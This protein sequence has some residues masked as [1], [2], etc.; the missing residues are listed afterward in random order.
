MNETQSDRLTETA[1]TVDLFESP[2][3][4][5]F[6]YAD[7]DPAVAA[8]ARATIARIK[9]R[10]HS[11]VCETGRDLIRI[12]RQMS[13]GQFGRWVACELGI[14]LRAAQNYMNVARFVVG[15]SE[16][17]SLLPPSALYA[18]AAPSASPAIVDEVLTA[19]NTGTPISA[20]EIRQKLN[21]PAA[22]RRTR[23]AVKSDEQLTRAIDNEKRRWSADLAR[24][25]KAEEEHE[26]AEAR[27]N[28]KALGV[29]QFLVTRLSA[30]DITELLSLLDDETDWNL[31]ET[32]FHC[33]DEQQ[34]STDET[35][36][37]CVP[38]T[39]S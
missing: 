13:H 28:T 21:A 30:R 25:K 39:Q 1:T 10:L 8:D 32:Y 36:T 14:S 7:I 33:L 31:V 35:E 5:W 20:D 27:R 9:T 3:P 19:V 38:D 16:S 37:R 4:L 26:A 23:S 6:N 12:K 18:L 17:I 11:S 15:K 29:A 24:Q 2:E 22:A 34:S